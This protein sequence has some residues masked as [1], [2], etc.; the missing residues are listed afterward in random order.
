VSPSSRDHDSTPT[1]VLTVVVVLNRRP[2]LATLQ[3]QSGQHSAQRS[4][5]AVAQGSD[6]AKSLG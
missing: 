6:P 3:W 2:G 4:Q 5:S 1:V